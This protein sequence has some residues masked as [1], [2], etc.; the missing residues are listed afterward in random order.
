MSA[1]PR[2]HVLDKLIGAELPRF[3]SMADV[4]AFEAQAPYDERVAAKS[5][6]E[7]LQLGAALNPSAPA[8]HFLASASP[9]EPPLTLTHAQF[10]SRVTQAANLFDALGVGAGDV[11]SLLLP[12]LPQAFVASL[13]RPGGGG[14][15]SG[16]P[17]ALGRADRRHPARCGHPR[18]GD[19]GP[20]R[21]LRHLG[22]GDGDPASACRA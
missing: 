3:E 15:Q 10:L 16:E 8:I 22:Q 20:Q 4:L 19:A 9:D 6:Y 18:A 13:R 14:C 11:V 1:P 5:T 7:A 17:D 21:R 2:A 12:L